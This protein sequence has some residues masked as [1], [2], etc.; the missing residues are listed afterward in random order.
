MPH[1]T[2]TS[3]SK[4]LMISSDCHAGALPSTYEKYMDKK[5]H[6]AARLWW[7]EFAREMMKRA[8][9]FFDQEA[10]E[11]YEG[12]A[13]SASRMSAPPEKAKADELS[14]AAFL[15]LLS[16]EHSAFAPRRGE[17][18]IKAFPYSELGTLL[19]HSTDGDSGKR[20]TK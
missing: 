18:D 4:V 8:G 9:T 15:D 7:V 11:A 5:H 19:I 2:R 17:C 20:S 10:V 16:D 6:E 14:D 1:P 12:K 13:G 3:D